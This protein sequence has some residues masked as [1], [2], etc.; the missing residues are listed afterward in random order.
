LSDDPVSVAGVAALSAEWQC[1]PEISAGRWANPPELARVNRLHDAV[2]G[3]GQR[4]GLK[5]DG[6]PDFRALVN[7]HAT[8]DFDLAAGAL[9][10][11]SA[12]TQDVAFVHKQR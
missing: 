6:E 8:H 9:D 5:L 3:V 12:H 10:H 7:R 1:S 2:E 11:G 4:P